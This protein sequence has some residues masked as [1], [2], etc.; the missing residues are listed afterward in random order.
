MNL[1]PLFSSISRSCLGS[2]GSP[3]KKK[4]DSD[5]LPTSPVHGTGA[6]A[7]VSSATTS[8][9]EE[10][11]PV[12][13]KRRGVPVGGEPDSLGLGVGGASTSADSTP[14]ASG[15]G[16]KSKYK[17]R[18]QPVPESSDDEAAVEVSSSRVCDSV[19]G[20]SRF[21][22]F[23]AFVSPSPRLV[24]LRL[25]GRVHLVKQPCGRRG[26]GSGVFLAAA[27]GFFAFERD[28]QAGLRLAHLRVGIVSF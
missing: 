8:T 28:R 17:S 22:P 11:T 6:A 16:R 18:P 2:R 13:S 25:V 4:R 1:I 12:L 10:D 20:K 5:A 26:S 9:A 3:T 21:C 14:C 24:L 23:L 27:A 7:T 19:E 15:S